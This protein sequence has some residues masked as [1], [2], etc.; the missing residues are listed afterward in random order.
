EGLA[1]EIRELTGSDS[2]YFYDSIAPILDAET[3]DNSIIYALSRYGKGDGAD[4]LNCPMDEETYARFH[5]ALVNAERVPLRDFEKPRYFEGCLPVEVMA[6]RGFDTLRYGPMKPVGLPDPRT[7]EIPHAVVQLRKE[8]KAG[9]AWNMVGF[10]TKLKYPEQARVFRMIP[11]LESVEFLRMGSIHRNTFIHSP[12]LLDS[13][14]RLLSQPRLRFAGQI[15]GV[16]GY[17]EST[18]SG[19]L[20][21]LCLLGD[22]RGT[23]PE[24]PPATTALGAMMGHVQG[25]GSGDFQPQNVNLGL[26]PALEHRV[27]K[28]E[29]KAAYTARAREDFAEWLKGLIVQ[30]LAGR[31]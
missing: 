1:E 27:K 28:R 24:L 20:T 3:L 12:S 7:D 29:R 23:P 14:N 8:N 15:T 31:V 11:G 18:A 30:P 21:A 16:E 10:Q 4:Y 26:F 17:V 19:L 6:E 13:G 22:R 2:L 25:G 5:D 9:T